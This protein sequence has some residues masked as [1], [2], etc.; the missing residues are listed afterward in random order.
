[1]KDTHDCFPCCCQIVI[2]H[3]AL[4]LATFPKGTKTCICSDLSDFWFSFMENYSILYIAK[5][6]LQVNF[7]NPL[8]FIE[9]APEKWGKWAWFPPY[10]LSSPR[11]LA[12]VAIT[13]SQRTYTENNCFEFLG[14][15]RSEI[16][17]HLSLFYLQK[18]KQNS[19]QPFKWAQS[20]RC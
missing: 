4:I 7:L 1:M 18:N 12:L 11:D 9:I 8:L 19:T 6:V 20:A 10:S 3:I 2:V 13:F 5:M 14:W 16:I 15:Y 17:T